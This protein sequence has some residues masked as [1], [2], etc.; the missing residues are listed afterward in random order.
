MPPRWCRRLWTGLSGRT[1]LSGERVISRFFVF[2][3]PIGYRYLFSIYVL[4]LTWQL[5]DLLRSIGSIWSMWS[6][7]AIWSIYGSVWYIWSV[8]SRFW[9]VKPRL[10]SPPSPLLT[11]LLI[12][13]MRQVQELSYPGY[14]PTRAADVFGTGWV[15]RG[16]GGGSHG[17]LW[18][19]HSSI[20]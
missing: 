17:P 19:R 2:L 12:Y 16:R 11:S 9:C 18:G 10:S 6:I 4:F 7:G 15:G 20:K 8:S 3:C 1:T 14:P 5:W 13:V